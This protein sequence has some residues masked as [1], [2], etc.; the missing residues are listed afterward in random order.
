MNPLAR[1]ALAAMFGIAATSA[2]VAAEGYP[3]IAFGTNGARI[4]D[5][6][7]AFVD[8]N[9]YETAVMPDGRIVAAG[10]AGVT[11]FDVTPNQNRLAVA[12]L[13]A[14]GTPD[15]SF[16]DGFGRLVVPGTVQHDGGSFH[17]YALALQTDGKIVVA[18]TY[19]G[20]DSNAN[21]FLVVRVRADGS[22]LDPT[23]ATNGVRVIPFDL[24]GGNID[25]ATSVAVQPD[26]RIVV[27]G[28]VRTG[29]VASD[30]AIV[31]LMPDGAFDV[32]FDGDGR[33]LVTFGLTGSDGSSY[34]NAGALALQPDGKIIV[35][36]EA[37]SAN[38]YDTVVARLMPNGALDA[39]F[40]NYLTGRTRLTYL[41]GRM[42]GARDVAI[43]ELAID[44]NHTSRR[45]VVA[46]HSQTSTVDAF[47]LA[48][49]K[50]DGTLDAGF[51]GDGKLLI[52]FDG[53]SESA[54]IATSVAI[55]AGWRRVGSLLVQYRQIVAG[56][57]VA[58]ASGGSHFEIA[59]A[60]ANFDGSL[61]AAFGNGGKSRFTSN[62]FS[63][64]G[65]PASCFGQSIAKQGAQLIVGAS[66][67]S[68]PGNVWGP[69]KFAWM[70]AVLD[71]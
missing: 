42:S 69:Q 61:D 44:P 34:D 70:R 13:L 43:S 22:G 6:Q 56:G 40:G 36:G 7:Q 46:G 64:F 71:E 31:R 67:R 63:L 35:A 53:P 52:P 32:S 2:A 16:G 25:V 51:S 12:R 20:P 65:P 57:Y 58:S 1:N 27:L 39:T 55:Q 37:S 15:P 10:I 47:A 19:L 45:I 9:L 21:D 54:S 4:V 14:D 62:H 18:G 68:R 48:V 11:P 33:R 59:L 23:F 17:P 24:G 41:A 66:C 5:F 26:G 50:D 8:D 60:R 29:A 28:S 3:D 38:G 30:M 49:L